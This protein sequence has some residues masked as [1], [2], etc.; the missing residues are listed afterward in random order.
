M[1][2]IIDKFFLLILV[3]VLIDENE[4]AAIEREKF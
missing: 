1:A 2:V 4:A 3:S